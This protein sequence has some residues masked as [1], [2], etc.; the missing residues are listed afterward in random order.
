VHGDTKGRLELIRTIFVCLGI[1]LSTALLFALVQA[2]P[3]QIAAEQA[4]SDSIGDALRTFHFR[5]RATI[6]PIEEGAGHLHVW[7]PLAAESPVQRVVSE[8]IDTSIPGEVGIEAEYGNRYWHGSLNASAGEKVTITV[9]TTVQRRVQH[10]ADPPTE[11]SP[12][13]KD[14]SHQ[15]FLKPNER[16]VVDHPI[17]EPILTELRA[18]SKGQGRPE[19]ARAIYDWV[20]DNVEYKKVGTG[21]GNGD[22]FWACNERY[23]NCTDF[24][25]LFISLARSEDIPARF[26]IG[27]PVPDDREQGEIGGYHCW[28]E[29]YLP[30][31]GWFPIDASE[32]SKRP[33]KRELFYGTQPADRIHFSTGRDLRL[34]PEHRDR[35][36]NYFVYPYVEV[37]GRAWQG[38]VEKAF[39]YYSVPD[40]SA[41]VIP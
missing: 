21:W 25:A 39:S 10:P 27:F 1:A 6:G 30:E 19:M 4:T 17:L 26:E 34:G 20:V 38:R 35:P 36:L 22:T 14:K 32:A 33:E 18:E 3:V 5:Y 28:V 31:T 40:Q 29:F 9:E 16:V 7:V 15:K 8:R 37:D 41:P 13:S 24:H 2:V 11:V 23:G 12:G